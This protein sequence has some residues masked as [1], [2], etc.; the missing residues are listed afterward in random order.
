MTKFPSFK[1]RDIEKILFKNDFLIKRQT[2]SHRVF[3][4]PKMHAVVIVPIHTRDVPTGTV[5]SIIKQSK[6]Q[7]EAF[8][9]K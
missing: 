5:R 7:E 1:A 6:L 9:K 4:N 2:G 8:L 3:Y